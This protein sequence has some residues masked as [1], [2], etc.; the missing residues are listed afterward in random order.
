MSSS[1]SVSGD[2]ATSVADAG[3]FRTSM[4][5]S[6]AMKMKPNVIIVAPAAHVNRG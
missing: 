4:T 3:F 6:S 1:V 2:S 5:A